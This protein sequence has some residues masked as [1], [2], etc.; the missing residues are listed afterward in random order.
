[1]TRSKGLGRGNAPGSRRA[2]Q[3]ANAVRHAQATKARQPDAA[4]IVGPHLRPF[5]TPAHMAELRRRK[6]AKRPQA[7][8]ALRAQEEAERQAREV[9]AHAEREHLAH[10][11]E[12]QSKRPITILTASRWLGESPQKTLMRVGRRDGFT[13]VRTEDGSTGVRAGD[14]E[15]LIRTDARHG[16]YH[17][18]STGPCGIG[19]GQILPVAQWAQIFGA[20]PRSAIVVNEPVIPCPQCRQALQ[21]G[22]PSPDGTVPYRCSMFLRCDYQ[23]VR[24]EHSW[25]PPPGFWG[26][27]AVPA[28]ESV[29]ERR[30]E[31]VTF[32]EAR[33]HFPD[34]EANL[35]PDFT[36]PPKDSIQKRRPSSLYK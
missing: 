33:A 10:D 3:T 5:Q 1:V 13:P 9:A 34:R 32:A 26:A 29:V 30:V 2:L 18:P 12:R 20:A 24:Q 23:A 25:R 8:A 11:R 31:A 21:A 28:P 17:K 14:V 22:S 19:D 36:I 4:P 15:Q 6:A 7:V 35:M 27:W 16:V